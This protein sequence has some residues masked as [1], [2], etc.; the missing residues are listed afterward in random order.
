MS[1]N[2]RTP[3]PHDIGRRE[4]FKVGGVG[5]V[6]LTSAAGVRSAAASDADAKP[7]I[8]VVITDQQHIDTIAAGGCDHIQTPA[9]DKLKNR[10]V[11]FTQSYSPNPVCSPAR[12][13]IFTGRTTTETGVCTNGK[14]I[15]AEIP[16]LGQ[17]FSEQS[18]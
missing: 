14:S 8:L 9:L 15:R 6:A 1:E 4:F 12:S 11:S 18:D 3:S 16:N 10:G 2:R 5:S 13:A 7:N 17:W